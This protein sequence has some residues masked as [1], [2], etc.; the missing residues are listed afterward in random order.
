MLLV[1]TLRRGLEWLWRATRELCDA[2]T[3]AC[4]AY[5]AVCL[6]AMTTSTAIAWY[7]RPSAFALPDVGH[8][9]FPE[10]SVIGTRNAH[11]ICDGL[12]RATGY[13]T[14]TFVMAQEQQ[15]RRIIWRRIFLIY[16]S[17]VLLRSVT[18]LMTALP[19]PYTLCAA[20]PRANFTWSHIPWS[21]IPL[22]VLGLLTGTGTG[23]TCGDSVFSGHTVLFVLCALVWH[24]YFRG[25]TGATA[26]NPVKLFVWMLSVVGTQLLIVTRMHWTLDIALAY[27]ITIT[28]WNFY[29][30]VCD[31]LAM[32]HYLKPVVFVDGAVMY[33]FIAWVETGS[34]F[35]EYHQNN[36]EKQRRQTRGTHF[37]ENA[38]CGDA[39]NNKKN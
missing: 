25:V 39:L 34:S 29:H 17:V 21:R 15:R 11:V 32:G 22:E 4:A 37:S 28:T 33:P 27:Y 24:T 10:V 31:A 7:R 14:A 2:R 5:C 35:A 8:D 13:A 6:V 19:D 12:L 23:M 1:L 3:L 16:G 26:V 18:L 30:G 9:F 38:D 36:E 20:H